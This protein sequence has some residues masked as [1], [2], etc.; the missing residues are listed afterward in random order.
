MYNN[1]NTFM[2]LVGRC[3]KNNLPK[4]EGREGGEK[5]A[6]CFGDSFCEIL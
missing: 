1:P 2:G 5:N 6:A 3:E 4:E